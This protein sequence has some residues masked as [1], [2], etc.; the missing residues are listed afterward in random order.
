MKFGIKCNYLSG[1]IIK[2]FTTLFISIFLVWFGIIFIYLNKLTTIYCDE[3]INDENKIKILK[4]TEKL[5][6]RKIFS[7]NYKPIIFNS[8]FFIWTDWKQIQKHIYIQKIEST[9]SYDH[10]YEVIYDI[11]Y[12]D[13]YRRTISRL[14]F[15]D[16][17]FNV[18]D[19]I[20]I[21]KTMH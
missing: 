16:K 1:R 13:D 12:D 3:S 9:D 5:F 18:I 20:F 11:N 15:L 2:V 6:N 10:I 19:E 17:N 7:S 21:G 14:Y 8:V 4:T